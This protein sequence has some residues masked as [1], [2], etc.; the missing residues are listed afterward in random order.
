MERS[1]PSAQ[2]VHRERS[3]AHHEQ[4]QVVG[5]VVAKLPEPPLGI[6]GELGQPRQAKDQ[7]TGHMRGRVTL[8][9]AE[10]AHAPCQDDHQQDGPEVILE[11]ELCAETRIQ[12]A[13]HA[14]QH[15]QQQHE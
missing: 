14:Q 8:E 12:A 11:D 13:R 4:P 3:D 10:V 9:V 2:E 5:V 6:H 1:R 7:G 15:E